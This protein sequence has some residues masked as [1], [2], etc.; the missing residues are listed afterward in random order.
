MVS[1]SRSVEGSNVSTSD[2]NLGVALG[3]SLRFADSILEHVKTVA[4]DEELSAVVAVRVLP[5]V[6]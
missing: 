4:L 2:R 3:A 5:P 6:A 1:S